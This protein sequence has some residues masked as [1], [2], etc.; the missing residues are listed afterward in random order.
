MTAKKVQFTGIVQTPHTDRSYPDGD[1]VEE[2]DNHDD[3][4]R[5]C[6]ITVGILIFLAF[7]LALIFT[8][9]KQFGQ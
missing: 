5:A 1:D 6:L 9:V 8:L 3:Y 7:M 4:V 2:E